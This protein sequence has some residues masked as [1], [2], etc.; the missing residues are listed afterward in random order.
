[1]TFIHS[2]MI[3][4]F[5]FNF[6]LITVYAFNCLVYLSFLPVPLKG[7]GIAAGSIFYTFYYL[8]KRSSLSRGFGFKYRT[9]TG[10][11]FYRKHLG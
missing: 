11:G 2:A 6:D 8:C 4:P 7:S 1:M 3:T 5:L 9:S 10:H